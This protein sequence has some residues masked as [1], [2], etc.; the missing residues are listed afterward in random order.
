MRKLL[1]TATFAVLLAGTLFAHSVYEYNVVGLD[2][3]RAATVSGIQLE[4]GSYELRVNRVR[5]DGPT[6]IP[7]NGPV[8]TPGIG[9]VA[10]YRNGKLLTKVFVNVRPLRNGIK[11]IS[12]K[13]AEEGT[14]AEI[15]MG[16][17]VVV[18]FN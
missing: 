8:S 3:H 10:I 16:K 13:Y 9:Q 11:P 5:F 7:S 2:L 15:R 12:I 1:L 14:I 6:L 17:E 4:S 18:F